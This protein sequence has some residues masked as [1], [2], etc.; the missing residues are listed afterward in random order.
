MARLEGPACPYPGAPTPPLTPLRRCANETMLFHFVT[1]GGIEAINRLVRD[2][3]DTE[4][5]AWARLEG[6][7]VRI[8]RPLNPPSC[9]QVRAWARLDVSERRRQA[10]HTIASLTTRTRLPTCC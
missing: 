6:L 2:T 3:S 5:R 9:P 7:C 8:S 4:V 10:Q 1:K